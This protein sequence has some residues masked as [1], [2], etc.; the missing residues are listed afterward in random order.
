MTESALLRPENRLQRG[1]PRLLLLAPWLA[2]GGADKFNLDL[3]AQLTQRGWAVTVVTTLPGDHSWLPHFARLTS[4]IVI[5]H[6]A[7]SLTEYPRF[8]CSLIQSRQAD[9]VLLSNSELGYRLLP[10]LRAHCP[11][12][13]FV[14]F[15]H[16]EEESWQKGGYPRMS[17]ERQELLDLQ[18]VASAYLKGWMVQRGAEAERVRVCYTNIDATQWQPDPEQRA[19]VRRELGVEDGVPVVLY[20]GR[21]RA[22]KQPRVF[23]HAVQRLAQRF[24][25]FVALVAGDGPELEWLRAFVNKQGLEG[26]VRLLGAVAN[27]RVRE[28]M[29]AADVFF[30]PSQWEGIALSLYEAMACGLPVVSADVGGQRE[31]VA[32]ECGVL[33]ARSDE[34]TEA[35]HYAQILAALLQEPHRRQAM[36]QAGRRRVTEH[37][38]L[39]GMGERMVALLQEAR[40]LHE[41]QPRPVP[42]LAVG[43]ACAAKTIRYLRVYALLRRLLSPSSRALLDRQRKWLLPLKETLDRVLL[44]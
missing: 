40:W 6:Q 19:A 25:S 23:A 4:D 20:A 32:P 31:L 17:V 8:L 3:L 29:A 13:T 22:Q 34:D 9:A 15:C 11:A 24:S 27:E 2:M 37:F 18:I 28:L 5:L 1:A 43:R 39:D 36:G 35:A 44:R 14:D 42:A 12:V 38:T 41:T 10:Y 33:V 21:I 7:A 30:L 26:Q 16:M